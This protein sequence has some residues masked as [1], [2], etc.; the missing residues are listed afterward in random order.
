MLVRMWRKE[1][2]YTAGGNAIGGA[3]MENY[4]GSFSLLFVGFSKQEY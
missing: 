4:G 1:P 2:F 3:A